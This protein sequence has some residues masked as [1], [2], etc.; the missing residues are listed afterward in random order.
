MRRNSGPG[1]EDVERQ[2]KPEAGRDAVIGLDCSTSAAKAVAFDRTGRALGEGR[3]SIPFAALGDDR[4]EQKPEDWW[5]AACLALRSLTASDPQLRLHALAIANQRETVA[6]LDAAFRPTR[7]A[8]LWL[9]GRARGDA[10]A[11]ADRLGA[12]T[13]HR[14]TGKPPDPNPALY[15]LAWM[16]R[17][18]PEVFAASRHFA[19]VHGYLVHRLTGDFATSTASADPL[20]VFDLARHRYAD[21]LL[22]EIGLDTGQFAPAAPPGT[23]L[24]HVTPEAAEATGLPAG[25]PIVAGAGDGQAAGLG[26]NILKPGRA[27]LNLGTA[28]VSG[29]YS[30]EY[31]IGGAF[32]TMIS[33]DGA[34]YVLETSLRSGTLLC[35]W[36]SRDLFGADAALIA[37]LEPAA[38]SLPPGAD[39]LFVLPYFLGVMTPHWDSAAR[40]AIIGLA[41]HHGQ[42][43]LLRALFEGIAHEQA[44]VTR[45]VA[46]MSG[47]RIDEIVAIGGGARSDLWCGII[48][49]VM[50]IPV[51]RSATLEASS[52]GA[53]IA[54]AIGAGWFG[55]FAEAAGEMA[56]GI[57]ARFT[58]DP[59][60]AAVYSRLAADYAE[61]YPRLKGFGAARDGSS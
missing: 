51:L 25:L 53:A 22:A 30:P 59:G 18:E 1:A 24:G 3:A 13:L 43:H 55:N 46:M 45:Q 52:L 38:S 9:D 31:R 42:A 15:K 2:G 7:P 16:R 34:G 47:A 35:D 60:R 26:T 44:S 40:G 14:I 8:I 17:E 4:F 56:G 49:D 20:G 36:L 32:R 58:P 48:A 37:A 50:N 23:V 19:E 33:G 6:P 21:A 41:P 12:E 29:L 27:Y 39:G 28:V 5:R 57:T 11:L 54:A 61:I 10:A